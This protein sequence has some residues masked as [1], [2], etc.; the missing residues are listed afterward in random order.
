M[1]N[2]WRL[3]KGIY[4]E[5]SRGRYRVRLYKRSKA[6]YLSY[7]PTLEEAVAALT[8]ARQAVKQM[9]TPEPAPLTIMR[10]LTSIDS[11]LQALLGGLPEPAV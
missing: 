2:R 6:V 10:D 3:P 7:H 8:Q 9:R 5:E 1:T 4:Y 11:Q